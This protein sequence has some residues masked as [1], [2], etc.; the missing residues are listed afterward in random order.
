MEA[1]ALYR[2]LVDGH[3]L[4][5]AEA[6]A[7]F[8]ALMSGDVD[9]VLFAGILTAFA[10]KGETVDELVGAAEAMRARVA[11][12]NAPPDVALI[13]TCGTG[14]D[15][16]PTFN[17][18]SAVAIVA[19]AVGATVAKHGNR[20]NARP[21]GSAEGLAALGI[22]VEADIPVLERCLRECRV[23]FLYAPRLHPAMRHAAPVRKALGIRTIF[24]LVGPLT[25]PAGARR[26]LMG[27]SRPDLV[28]TMTS[29]LAELG[30]ERALVVHGRDGLCDL[31]ISA[32]TI[33]GRWDGRQV[34]FEEV[35]A[36]ALGVTTAPLQAVFV[37][38]P[39]ESAGVIQAVLAGAAGPAREMV[40]LNAAAA[41]WVAGLVDDWAEGVSRARAALADGSAAGVL[42]RWREIAPAV[43]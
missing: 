37:G 39:Q 9:P 32:P 43:S 11:R 36:D 26:Q 15:G 3:S 34:T 40:V 12:V 14:G 16:K 2:K 25:N 28:E 27:V 33:V 7:L 13:D 30:A 1:L 31:S 35:R 17:V 18:S 23:A 6:R 10:A 8:D 19:A 20:S 5:R 24:N 42:A 4:A 22:N 41:L 21:S 29:A 38:S